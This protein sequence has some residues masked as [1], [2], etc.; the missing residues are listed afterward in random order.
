MG[1]GLV[2]NLSSLHKG[3]DV[4]MRRV[5]ESY[6]AEYRQFVWAVFVRLLY[7]TPQYSG[8]AVASWN[9][10][11]SDGVGPEVG[12]TGYKSDVL[13]GRSRLEAL[14]LYRNTDTDKSVTELTESPNAREKGDMR[15][16]D[17]ARRRNAK[18]IALIKRRTRVF[19][20]NTAQGDNNAKVDKDRSLPEKFFYLQALQEPGYWMAKLREVNKPYETL[21]E[22]MSI[23]QARLFKAGR[24]QGSNFGYGSW[25]KWV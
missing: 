23:M 8:T 2:K 14:S 25:E 21:D 1:R 11:L 3:I 5:E 20:V 10:V 6:V 12:P 15:A 9:I 16:I 24:N 22:T 4:M 17:Y 18:K 7:E 19:F 13:P